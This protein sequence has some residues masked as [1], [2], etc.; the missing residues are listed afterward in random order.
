MLLPLK[1]MRSMSLLG[2]SAPPN[3]HTRLAMASP[4]ATVGTAKAPVPERI[5]PARPSAYCCR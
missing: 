5:A 2:F 1:A 3:R 4:A